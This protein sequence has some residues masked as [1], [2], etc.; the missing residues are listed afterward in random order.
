MAR[1]ASRR[2]GR[3]SETKG[4]SKKAAAVAEVE[5]VEEEKGLGVNDGIAIGTTILFLVAILLTDYTLGTEYG[6]GLFFAK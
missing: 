1:K 4:R 3:K 2:S 6:T 5:V